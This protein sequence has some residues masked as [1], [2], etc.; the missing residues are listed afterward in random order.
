MARPSRFVHPFRAVRDIMGLSQEKAAQALGISTSTLQQ[1]ERG[2]L[3]VSQEIHLRMRALSGADIPQGVCT[4]TIPPVE[5]TSGGPYDA[6]SL[7][8]WKKNPY[9]RERILRFI[10]RNL[11]LFAEVAEK[12]GY[13]QTFLW[14]VARAMLRLADDFGIREEAERLWDERNPSPKKPKKSLESKKKRP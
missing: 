2:I 4:E 8:R 1:I 11:P 10:D 7:E 5:H 6:G 9:H 12:R 13:L 3:P 14:A